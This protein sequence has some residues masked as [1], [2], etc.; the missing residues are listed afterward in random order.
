MKFIFT[1]LFFGA[2]FF[3]TESFA[4]S[5]SNSSDSLALKVK[6]IVKKVIATED[7]DTEESLKYVG[8]QLFF[9]LKKR[10]H[11][12]DELEEKEQAKSKKAKKLTFFGI[13][14]ERN[15]DVNY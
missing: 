5:A 7:M 9:Q 15:G 6:P 2:F 11:L 3:S 10:L 12:T 4:Q 14:I 13:E 1:I 8:G